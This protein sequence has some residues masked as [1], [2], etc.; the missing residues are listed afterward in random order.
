[1]SIAEE[2]ALL[3]K[4]M[5]AK[6]RAL[7]ID[8][9]LKADEAICRHVRNSAEYAAAKTIFGYLGVGWEIDT[10]PLLEQILQDGKRLCLPLCTGPHEMAICV[11]NDLSEL[12]PGAYNIPEPSKES[13]T[14][15]PE[16]VDLTLV[17]CVAA[18]PLG[19]RL[20]Q[21]GGY[22]DT[23]LKQYAG[24]AFLLCREAALLPEI[25]V[26]NHDFFLSFL[27]TETNVFSFDFPQA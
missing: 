12:V 3:R 4:E 6:S 13:L 21:G 5:R 18:D 14:I 9:R 23:F 10:K 2:K 7:P 27:V 25:P 19:R 20:G 11:V 24:P 8:Y 1:M 17:P 26:E 22:Y 16:E 15:P